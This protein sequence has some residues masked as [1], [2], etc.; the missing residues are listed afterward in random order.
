LGNKNGTVNANGKPQNT[1]IAFGLP[2]H[3]RNM[4]RR[5]LRSEH[6]YQLNRTNNSML[7]SAHSCGN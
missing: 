4:D 6:F 2:L 7:R 3:V 5:W 1:Q